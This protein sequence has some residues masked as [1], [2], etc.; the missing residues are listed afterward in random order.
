MGKTRSKRNE[1]KRSIQEAQPENQLNDLDAD[2]IPLDTDDTTFDAEPQN[3]TSDSNFAFSNVRDNRSSFFG[4]LDRS[5]LEYFKNAENVLATNALSAEE[6]E[7]FVES[8]FTEAKGKELKLATNQVCSKLLERMIQ[9]ANDEQLQQLTSAFE[10]FA[11]DVAYQ[12]FSSHCLETL[13]K[14]AAQAQS[15]EPA[16]EK[17][18][19]SLAINALDLMYDR[20]GS[21]V[22]STLVLTLSG[23][24]GKLDLNTRSKKSQLARKHTDIEEDEEDDVYLSIDVSSELKRVIRELI[25]NFI[26]ELDQSTARKLAI[27]QESSPVIQAIAVSEVELMSSYK[28]INLILEDSSGFVSHCLSDPVGSHFIETVIKILPAKRV[29]KFIEKLPIAKLATSENE[30][31][32]YIVQ[33]ILSIQCKLPKAKKLELINNELKDSIKVNKNL[34]VVALSVDFEGVARNITKELN[35]T[36]IDLTNDSNAALYEKLSNFAPFVEKAVD[37]VISMDDK[38]ILSMGLDP[39]KSYVLQSLL[40][41]EIPLITRRK[42]I[43]RLV[44]AVPALAVNAY[45]S[46]IID[47]LW[48]ATFK[49]KFVRER[50]A[51]ELLKSAEQVKHSPYGKKVWKNFAMEKYT[52]RRHD[53]WQIVKD[54][55]D[56]LRAE[57]PEEVT[58]KKPNMPHKSQNSKGPG[59]F[60]PAKKRRT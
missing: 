42:L 20:Y 37:A 49:L 14:K 33:T 39:T 35:P 16:V 45:G 58:E 15:C 4:L 11:V 1:K 27:N 41:P 2:F 56:K 47:S 13:I 18:A 9:L 6:K 19:R 48:D 30:Y 12:K 52:H 54:H 29:A 36:S 53:W 26:A 43:N 44:A 7:P 34:A 40:K 22:L 21:H 5:E 23:E 46:H 32:R 24:S 25:I 31:S 51:S 55:E 8:V 59:S 10:N 3:G 50:V 28:L 57:I 60:P 17:I 38:E